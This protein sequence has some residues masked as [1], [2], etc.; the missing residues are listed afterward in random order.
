MFKNRIVTVLVCLAGVVVLYIVCAM[1]FSTLLRTNRATPSTGAVFYYGRAIIIQ[2]ISLVGTAYGCRIIYRNLAKSTFGAVPI[3][4]VTVVLGILIYVLSL[5]LVS[6]AFK[7]LDKLV[8]Q[9]L[10]P[11]G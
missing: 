6:A 3:V 9:T 10:R 7:F 2:L 4:S 11:N 8:F 1:Y 5:F